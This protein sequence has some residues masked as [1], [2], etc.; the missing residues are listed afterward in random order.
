MNIMKRVFTAGVA[1]LALGGMAATTAATTASASTKPVVY[2]GA[3]GWRT[4]SLP[5]KITLQTYHGRAIF[6]ISHI[7]W[8]FNDKGGAHNNWTALGN[9]REHAFD[10]DGRWHSSYGSV[11]ATTPKWHNGVRYYYRLYFAGPTI[12]QAFAFVWRN[13]HWN[14]R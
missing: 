12:Y 11:D 10:S 2:S 13:G 8:E 7:K 5:G 1:A 14:A 6:Y 4:N 3:H 9:G